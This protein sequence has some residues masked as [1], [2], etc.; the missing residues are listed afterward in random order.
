MTTTLYGLTGGVGMGKSTV[1]KILEKK[2]MLVVDSDE[3]ARQVV[4]PG[5]PALAE[6]IDQFGDGIIDP[7]GRLDRAKMAQQVFGDDI[8]REQLEAI[9]HP[10][11]RARW[12]MKISEWRERQI[13][14]GVVVIPLLFEV[15]VQ[16]QFDVVLCVACTANTQQ[17]RLRHRKWDEE[18]ISARNASQMDIAEKMDLADHVLWTEGD[19][20]VTLEQ[21]SR[22]F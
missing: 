2:G 8:A 6:I 22:I 20:K 14:A 5:Q 15:E 19:I 12:K 9:I 13:H 7:Q 3:L 18:Q 4:E 16:D 21:V 10:R 1:A 11:V 17:V